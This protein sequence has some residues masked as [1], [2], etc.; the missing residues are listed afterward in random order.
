MYVTTENSM[1]WFTK[2]NGLKCTR[3]A[4]Y[5]A[6]KT[7][8]EKGSACSQP[9]LFLHCT[10]TA[11]ICDSGILQEQQWYQRN[12]ITLLNQYLIGIGI[13]LIKDDIIMV[14]TENIFLQCLKESHFYSGLI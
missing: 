3:W 4:A 10:N 12:G 7:D 5:G 14:L 11:H 9:S 13:V 2:V 6:I 8:S 1:V